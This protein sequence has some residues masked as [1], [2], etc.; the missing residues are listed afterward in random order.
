[1]NYNQF[2][3]SVFLD[4]THSIVIVT[5]TTLINDVNVGRAVFYSRTSRTTTQRQ[6]QYKA[7]YKAISCTLLANSFMLIKGCNIYL[8][9]NRKPMYR[10]TSSCVSR[11]SYSFSAK[12]K[13]LFLPTREPLRNIMRVRATRLFIVFIEFR[14]GGFPFFSFL[15]RFLSLPPSLAYFPD[16]AHV[17]SGR[18]SEGNL[19]LAENEVGSPAQSSHAS[20][21]T[22]RDREGRWCGLATR[23]MPQ[24]GWRRSVVMKLNYNLFLKDLYVYAYV[25]IFS[26]CYSFLTV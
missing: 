14:A 9:L 17:F 20:L 5:L 18:V 3:N 10:N 19:S 8:K 2:L 12:G 26:A 24:G 4:I 1:M 21:L 6:N 15:F 22:I 16:V 23:G 11:Y 13:P 7:V 25:C